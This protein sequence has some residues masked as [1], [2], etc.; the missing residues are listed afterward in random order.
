MQKVAPN[1]AAVAGPLLGARLITLAGGLD[2]LARMP[3]S[4]IQIIGA[5]RA[6]FRYKHGEG[7]P[8]KH[9]V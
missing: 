9:G 6:L 2:R 5:E 4:T 1:L 7:T 8:P 3:A